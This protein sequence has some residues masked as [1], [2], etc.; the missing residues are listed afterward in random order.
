MNRFILVILVMLSSAS[1]W[2]QKSAL[3]GEK[4]PSMP[5]KEFIYDNRIAEGKS[6]YI[7]FFKVD[8]PH[9]IA[10]L[11]YLAGFA[12]RYRDRLNFIVV[13]CDSR[14]DVIS[15]FGEGD[16]PYSVA[17]DVEGKCHKQYNV[18]YVPTSVLIDRKGSFVWQGRS[19]E[20]TDRDILNAVD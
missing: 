20:L 11:E 1:L 16:L 10:Q 5:I 8:S 14:G 2:G 3:F 13:S 12:H 6:T 19:S 17:I 18:N 7:E 9:S 4:A 15:F